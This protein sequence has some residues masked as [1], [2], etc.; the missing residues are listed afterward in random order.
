MIE[1]GGVGC[2]KNFFHRHSFYPTLRLNRVGKGPFWCIVLDLATQQPA[3]PMV[4]NDI[5]QV[6]SNNRHD[7]P[8]HVY[9]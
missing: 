7:I 8:S 9:K 3:L 1:R 4:D 6:I 2:M 5:H